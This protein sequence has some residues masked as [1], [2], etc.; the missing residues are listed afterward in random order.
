MKLFCV[1]IYLFQCMV[2]DENQSLFDWTSIGYIDDS[3]LFY[4]VVVYGG[5][6]LCSKTYK[7]LELIVGTLVKWAI[8]QLDNNWNRQYSHSEFSETIAVT[9]NYFSFFGQWNQSFLFLS[10][11]NIHSNS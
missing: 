5:L 11:C 10:M 1:E 9:R 6:I 4:P 3:N 2:Q 7:R 8:Q